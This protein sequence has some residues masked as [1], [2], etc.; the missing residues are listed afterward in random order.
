MPIGTAGRSRNRVDDSSL[1]V[2]VSIVVQTRKEFERNNSGPFCFL[3][4]NGPNIIRTTTNLTC[5][6]PLSFVQRTF[7]DN[8][9]A[10]LKK[11]KVFFSYGPADNN[12][13]IRR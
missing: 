6:S 13:R 12:K 9:H 10:M 7:A 8:P 11:R 3:P 5:P 2:D 4:G 1:K